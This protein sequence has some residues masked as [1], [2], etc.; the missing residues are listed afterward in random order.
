MAT[1][2]IIKF[3]VALRTSGDTLI[4]INEIDQGCTVYEDTVTK[5]KRCCILLF[6]IEFDHFPG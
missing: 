2:Q 1:I 3:T 4:K 6:E 5:W